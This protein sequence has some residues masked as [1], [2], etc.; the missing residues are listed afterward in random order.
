VNGGQKERPQRLTTANLYSIATNNGN[1]FDTT[2][3]V[4]YEVTPGDIYD[5]ANWKY[6]GP[7]AP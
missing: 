1:V 6:L 7:E 3:G 5:S 4:W 2:G